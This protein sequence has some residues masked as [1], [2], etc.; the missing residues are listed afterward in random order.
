M[1][2]VHT[3]NI[4]GRAIPPKKNESGKKFHPRSRMILLPLF[5]SD[6]QLARVSVVDVRPAR[7]S[8]ANGRRRKKGESISASNPTR[9]GQERVSFI[10]LTLERRSSN[11]GNVEQKGKR[12]RISIRYTFQFI[13]TRTLD[14]WCL[15][16]R[17]YIR[18]LTN[19]YHLRYVQAGTRWD[20][21]SF[22]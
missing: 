3:Y 21:R 1:L 8:F 4:Q 11:V 9:S 22:V 10:R 13:S 20:F 6:Q 7:N 12:A 17:K 18:R 5:K 16:G 15:P 14:L 19:F 2:R